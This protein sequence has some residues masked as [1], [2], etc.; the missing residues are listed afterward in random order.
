MSTRAT[1]VAR[2]RPQTSMWRRELDDVVRGMSGGFLFGIPLIYTMEVWWIGASTSAP[3]MLGAL[4]FSFVVVLLLVR[5]AGFR[6]KRDVRLADALYDSL[7]ALA[8]GLVACLLLLLLMNQIDSSTPLRAVLG[9]TVFEGISFTLG[10]ALAN[11]FLQS[12]QSEGRDSGPQQGG[13]QQDKALGSTTADIGATIIGATIIALNI[14][15]T[16]E[17]PMISSAVAP[18]RLLLFIVASLVI[19]YAIVFEAGFR[20]QKR[21]RE[22]HGIFQHPLSETLVSYLVSLLAAAF[23]LWFFQRLNFDDPWQS[24]LTQSIVL[25]LPATVGGAAGR[26]AI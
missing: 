24:W 21:R 1:S 25:G 3:R 2:G 16:D 20:D 12:D 11:Q 23:M 7:E 26:L 8:I 18:P 22:Q 17:V 9:K 14:A 6:R 5:T 10:V 19:S 4:L 15:P 13:T